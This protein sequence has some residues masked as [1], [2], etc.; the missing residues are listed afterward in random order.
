[1][2]TQNSSNKQAFANPVAELSSP[3]RTWINGDRTSRA[4]AAMISDLTE[5]AIDAVFGEENFSFVAEATPGSESS[6]MVQSISSQIAMLE[7]Q[8]EQLRKILDTVSVR[9]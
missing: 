9:S 7:S 3:A 2:K 5:D 1:M 6:A 4:D 8:C